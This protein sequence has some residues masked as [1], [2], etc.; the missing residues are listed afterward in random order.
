LTCPTAATVPSDPLS[1]IRS[2]VQ[3]LGLKLDQA[4]GPDEF[5]VIDHMERPSANECL[6]RVEKFPVGQT[7]VCGGLQS[8][9]EP[10]GLK[11]R[12]R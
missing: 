7:L 10:A 5:L 3:K 11:S 2:A 6:D 4:K 1:A 12:T 9:T 8:A